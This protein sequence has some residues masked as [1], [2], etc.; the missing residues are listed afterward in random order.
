MPTHAPSIG[1][2]QRR[3]PKPGEL[4][5]LLDGVR[6]PFR[7]LR[8][9]DV[10]SVNVGTTLKSDQ[11]HRIA[12]ALADPR[13]YE[14]LQAIARSQE[15]ACSDLRCHFPISA[16]TLSHHIKELSNAG[17]IDVRREAKFM[18]IKLR[19]NAWKAYLTKL[20]KL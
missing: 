20:S 16:A 4:F 3:L 6:P 13:R 12:K 8:F 5:K 9:N 7:I 1:K 19:R 11:F 17:L 14:I 2:A 18:H 10:M 15:T